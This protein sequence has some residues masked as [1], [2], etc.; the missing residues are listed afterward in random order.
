[1]GDDEIME[2]GLR[3]K[4]RVGVVVDKI[5]ELVLW[6][7]RIFRN[8]RGEVFRLRGLLGEIEVEEFGIGGKGVY[9]GVKGGGWEEG[10]RGEY[11]RVV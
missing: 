9:V 10:E 8:I 2:C 4:E 1:M 5:C 7:D 3:K 6:K 11:V